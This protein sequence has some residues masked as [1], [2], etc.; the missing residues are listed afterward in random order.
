MDNFSPKICFVVAVDITLN[1]LLLSQMKFFQNKGYRV[2][3]V[4]SPGKWIESIE[5]EGIEIKKITI[6]R[7][8]L[9]PFSDLIS[10]VKLFFYFKKEK[11]DAVFT[12]TPKPGL[13]GQL[14]AKMA[15]VPV[16]ANTIFGY[17]F[18]EK[19]PYLKRKFFIFIEKIAGKCSDMIF[20]RNKEDFEISKKEHIVK[21]GLAQYIGDGIDITKYNPVRFSEE[22][23][24]EKKKKL[25]IGE[26]K[27][28]IGIVARLVKEK[29]YIEL[30]EAFK[31]VLKKFPNAVL[32]VVGTADLQKKDSISPDIV[33]NFGI[34]KDVIFLGERTDVVELYSIMDIF[35]LPSH[36]EGFPHSVMEAS[37]MAKPVITT[38]VRGCRSA[39]N[40][41][42]T[43]IIVP[44]KNSRALADALMYILSNPDIAKKMGE[45]GR[46][47]AKKEFDERILFD[48]MQKICKELTI[49]KHI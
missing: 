5:K 13:L 45:R 21:N 47:K 34:E 28:V 4:C 48:K 22:F 49:Q 9:S 3:A 16:I 12:F 11:F 27:S 42:I 18:H 36:R 17:Y 44:P 29:G 23:I 46:I 31:S 35:V 20:F 2:F 15:Q 43:G 41:T 10:I 25:G 6:K 39:V 37:A 30:F 14:A 40:N 7:K 38:D 26:E 33:K 8:A 1:F 24:K 32:L 19:T